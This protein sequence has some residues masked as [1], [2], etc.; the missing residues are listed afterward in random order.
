MILFNRGFGNRSTFSLVLPFRNVCAVYPLVVWSIALQMCSW[1][2]IY[3]L[4]AIVFDCVCLWLCDENT[5]FAFVFNVC[6]VDF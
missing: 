4:L 3:M 1:C 2:A 6:F 5:L